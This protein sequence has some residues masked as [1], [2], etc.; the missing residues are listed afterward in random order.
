[1]WLLADE[2]PGEVAGDNVASVLTANHKTWKAY[3]ES[4][5]QAGYIGDDRGLYVK[6]HNPFA[7]FASVR[8]GRPDAPSQRASI[9]PFDQFAQDLQR[10]TLPDYSFI[11]PNLYNDGHNDSV[12]KGRAS[13]GDHRALRQADEWLK[14]SITPL[15]GSAMFQRGGLLIIVFDEACE[16]GPKADASYDPARRNLGGGGHVAT[17]VISSLT[18]AGT[19]TGQLLHHESVLRLSLSALGIEQMPG[20]AAAAPDMNVFFKPKTP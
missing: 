12:T 9:V 4:L 1:V 15:I 6:R 17:V 20:S 8:H 14:N 7:Y 13:C 16:N 11:S 2:Y 18:P 3:A 5:P 10:D 19:R